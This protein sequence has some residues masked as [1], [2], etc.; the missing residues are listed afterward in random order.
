MN[1]NELKKLAAKE[2]I[3]Q[4]IPKLSTNSILGIG[5]GSTT[6][7]FIEELAQY[8]N[9]FD[10]AVS[11]SEATTT[12]LKNINIPVY[13]LNVVDGIEFYIDGA[14]EFNQ[15]LE[16]IKGGG[17]ALT[18]EKIIATVSKQFICIVDETKQVQHLGQF[19]IPIEVIPMARSYVAR[20]IIKLKGNPIY[21]ENTITDN[22]NIILDIHDLKITHADQLE[23]DINNIAGVVC[24][25]IFS[26]RKADQVII[27]TKNGIKKL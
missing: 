5:T 23:Q 12:K 18:R 1:Q 10:G 4:I 20:E 6:N 17:A 13:D 14:D 27:A 11:S 25:G 16:L 26:H 19:P 9:L 15:N 21:R 24:N 3:K 2:A 7:F 22:G 8:A